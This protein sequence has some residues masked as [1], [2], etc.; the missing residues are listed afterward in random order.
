MAAL[1]FVLCLTWPIGAAG[2]RPNGVVV[3]RVR[4]GGSAERADIEVGD[5]LISWHVSSAPGAAGALH[6]PLDIHLLELSLAPAA[7]L[8]LIHI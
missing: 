3:E 5:L 8:S 1:A 6:T 4:P 7:D 2:V